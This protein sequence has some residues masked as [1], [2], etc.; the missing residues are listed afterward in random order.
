MVAPRL[1][2]LRC[3]QV[4]INNN[5]LPCLLALLTN[6][7]K[8][9]IK[10]EACWTISNITAGNKEQIQASGPPHAGS[11]ALPW[12][13]RSRSVRH[14]MHNLAQQPCPCLCSRRWL[15]HAGGVIKSSD[16]L[17]PCA[18]VYQQSVVDAG[19]IPPLVHLLATAEFDI[20]KE[21]A[22][23]I[24]NATSGGTHDQIK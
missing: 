1:A 22:W 3:A 14:S 24:S 5:A 15:Q 16:C 23:A 21:A 12:P 6:N 19:I 10:K 2:M 17:L 9:S 13:M 8:K 7:H 18:V 4:I 20:K 11:P